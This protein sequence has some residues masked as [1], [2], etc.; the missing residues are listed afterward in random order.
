MRDHPTGGRQRKHKS[1]ATGNLEPPTLPDHLR[2]DA[3]GPTCTDEEKGTKRMTSAS[4]TPRSFKG[5]D[6]DDHDRVM[7]VTSMGPHQ[8]VRF[9]EGNAMESEVDQEGVDHNSNELNETREEPDLHHENAEDDPGAGRSSWGSGKVSL[10][11][12]LD[13]LGQQFNPAIPATFASGANTAGDPS[14]SPS[15]IVQP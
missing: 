12:C 3:D 13:R 5:A 11:E 15:L 1:P 6:P 4:T 8:T 9:G 2:D 14:Q 10:Q 7:G